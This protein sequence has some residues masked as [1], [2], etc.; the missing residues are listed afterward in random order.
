MHGTNLEVRLKHN[1]QYLQLEPG[2]ISIMDHYGNFFSLLI[3]KQTS[4]ST[5]KHSLIH[6]YFSLRLRSLLNYFASV[7]VCNINYGLLI[8]YGS[9]GYL[10]RQIVFVQ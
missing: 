2:A 10:M 6:M 1:F 4:I 8:N 7:C 3:F 9:S 5:L